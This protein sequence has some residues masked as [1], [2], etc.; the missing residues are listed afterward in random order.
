MASRNASLAQASLFALPSQRLLT[1]YW[2]SLRLPLTASRVFLLTS[3]A[4][5]AQSATPAALGS[6]CNTT[7]SPGPDEVEVCI[8]SRDANAGAEHSALARSAHEVV[9]RHEE[10]QQVASELRTGQ[11]PEPLT[12]A[13]TVPI[14]QHGLYRYRVRDPMSP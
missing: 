11:D 1:L 3:R 13:R 12:A 4:A 6:P 5:L 14:A 2:A 8:D 9:A 7:T 10:A